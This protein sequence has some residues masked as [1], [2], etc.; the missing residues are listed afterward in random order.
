MFGTI[1]LRYDP[2]GE[3]SREASLTLQFSAEATLPEI[4]Q[5][6]ENF[7]RAMEYPLDSSEKLA[8]QCTQTSSDYP[9]TLPDS[10]SNFSPEEAIVLNGVR[11]EGEP[12]E[13][14]GYYESL[15]ENP[16]PG[17]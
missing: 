11:F 9:A 4:L 15:L 14:L 17:K 3:E 6:F 5:H 16:F 13:P 1:T 12:G 8:I 7:L 10:L 2:S